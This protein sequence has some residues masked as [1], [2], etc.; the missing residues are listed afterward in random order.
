MLFGPGFAVVKVPPTEGIVAEWFPV[1]L[2]D[3]LMILF[4]PI[5]FSLVRSIRWFEYRR[6]LAGLLSDPV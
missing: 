4:P 2:P 6:L 1:V 3:V 5:S